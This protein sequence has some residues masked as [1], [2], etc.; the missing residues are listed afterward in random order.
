MNRPRPQTTSL[1]P[2]FLPQTR[3]VTPR[4]TKTVPSSSNVRTTVRNI[5][6]KTPHFIALS[7]M[8]IKATPLGS[9]ASSRKGLK[10]KTIL[11]MEKVLQE[12]VQR[13]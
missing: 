8:K 10:I 4:D 7:M 3:T 6:R 5:V 2:I 13:T 1:W 12:E 9:V 11:N